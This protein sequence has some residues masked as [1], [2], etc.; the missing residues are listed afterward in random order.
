MKIY[1]NTVSDLLW[2]VLIKLMTIEELKSFRLVGGTS[3]SLL[4][5]HRMSDDIDMFTDA[6]YN[7]LDFDII[8]KQILSS[9]NYVEFGYGGNNSMGKSYFIGNSKTDLVKVDLFYTDSFIFPIVEYQGI[10]I[11]QLEEIT[12]MKLEV[13]GQNG[14]KK[15]FWDLHELMDKF[16]W[17]EMMEFY[18]RRY[19]YS[20]SQKEIVAKLID[21]DEADNDLEPICLQG[22]YWKLVKLDIEESISNSFH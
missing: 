14:R 3:L 15:D 4:L 19:P 17:T 5:G 13:V 6:E 20:Y 10:R 2:E 9:F 16:T 7:S 12:A 8:D 18:Q 1:R 22:K 11:S 21:F